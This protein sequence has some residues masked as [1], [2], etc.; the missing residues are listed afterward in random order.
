[1]QKPILLVFI[2]FSMAFLAEA[3]RNSFGLMI[4]TGKGFV[5][6]QAL[7]GAAELNLNQSFSIGIEYNRIIS[8][9]YAF[10]TGLVWYKNQV[11]VAPA[12][13][14]GI[15]MTPVNYE[16]QLLYI[17]TFLKVNFSKRFF[18]HG[19]FLVDIDISDSSYISSQSGLGAGLGV[20]TEVSIAK[21]LIMSINPYVNLHGIILA[22]KENY[23]E[24]ILDSGIK[25]GVRTK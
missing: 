20:G 6:Q 2:F 4:G 17:P 9:K 14:P 15:D 21:S 16:I 22:D 18:M 7:E 1:M 8:D 10:E 5:A 11:S 13:Y 12:F 3:Q 25:I 24:R 19:G 23:P